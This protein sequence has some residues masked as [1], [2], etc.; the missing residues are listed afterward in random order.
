MEAYTCTGS[1]RSGYKKAPARLQIVKA[2]TARIGAD[3]VGLRLSPYGAF[4]HGSLDDEVEELVTYLVKELAKLKL[5]YLHCVEPRAQGHAS[6]EPPPGQDLQKFRKVWPVRFRLPG[7]LHAPQYHAQC[8]WLQSS[9]RTLESCCS[10]IRYDSS[11]KIS[12]SVY[13]AP[14]HRRGAY[15]MQVLAGRHSAGLRYFGTPC[16]APSW[17]LVA[18]TSIQ[19]MLLLRMGQQ[20]SSLMGASGCQRLICQS[21]LPREHRSTTTTE[22]PSTRLIPSRA[23]LTTRFWMRSRRIPRRTC[24][25]VAWR[26]S[27]NLQT[28]LRQAFF[29]QDAEFS[30]SIQ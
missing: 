12:S 20:I 2:V 5:V 10:L 19:V 23:T 28:T 17:Q 6:V 7:A 9:Q 15:C 26:C 13:P 1:C 8:L 22:T 24:T 11:C 3:R 25:T 16:R 21:A 14:D 30:I 4:L 18:T 27:S 29:M